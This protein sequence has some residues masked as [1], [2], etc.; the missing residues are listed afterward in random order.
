VRLAEWNYAGIKPVDKP[1]E[2]YKVEC[3]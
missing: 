3:R 1:A 2:R